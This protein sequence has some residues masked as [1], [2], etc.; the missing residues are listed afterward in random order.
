MIRV[1]LVEDDPMVAELNR[2]FVDQMDGFCTVGALQGGQ[3]ALAFLRGQEVDLILLDIYMPGQ[4]G[5]ELLAAIRG[6]ALD[7]DVIFVTAARDPRT[8]SRAL[9]L[10]A[11]DY[12]IKPFEFER[13]QL[14][15]ER[16]RETHRRMREERLVSQSEMDR[17]FNLGAPAQGRLQLPKGLDRNTLLRICAALLEPTEVDNWQTSEAFARVIGIS[18][19]SIRK[20]FECLSELKGLQ[21]E[22]G[23]G[24]VGRPVHRFKPVRARLEEIRRSL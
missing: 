4:T 23:Y 13:L 5:L 8:I 1:L 19:V 12:L 2:R 15:L 10:G 9:K 11:V 17:V 24:G 20:Y 22:F 3:E 14:A 16:Y 7:V 6:A 18:R 21:V